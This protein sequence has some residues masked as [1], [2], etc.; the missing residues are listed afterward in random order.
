[1][2]VELVSVIVCT[3]NRAE[4]LRAALRDLTNQQTGD[5]FSVEILVVDDR[6]TDHTKTVVAQA[7]SMASVPVR[8]VRG[9]GRGYTRALNAGL[10]ESRGKWLAFF[11]DDQ[12]AG[13]E[14]LRDLF[15]AAVEKDAQLVGGP[16]VLFFLQPEIARLGPVCR[17]LCGEW[18]N[19]REARKAN[20][21]PLPGGGNRL[22]K[23][24]VF[25]SIGGFDDAIDTGGAD[26]DLIA[27]ASA[28]GFH[29]A[30][31]PNAVVQHLI[32]TERTTPARIRRYA[33]QAGCS[34][35]YI[36]RKNRGVWK[37]LLLCAARIGQ[38]L[39]VKLPLLLVA[40][41]RGNPFRI[42][43]V[44]ASLWITNGYTRGTL[45]HIAPQ[46]FPQREFYARSQFRVVGGGT[47]EQ[48]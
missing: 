30:W 7:A 45:Y 29:F 15:V 28:A 44:K 42:L 36:H 10:A 27:R 26:T 5:S 9:D 31:A 11:D 48:V 34:V 3:Y 14:W 25:D 18:P 4:M 19:A 35:A 23:R 13:P 20:H 38:V 46:L 41:S 32:P 21:V 8:Y 33:L 6:S 12:L 39:L 37:M 47:S 24:T 43:D 17:A 2:S 16:I 22:V 1:M 40:Y